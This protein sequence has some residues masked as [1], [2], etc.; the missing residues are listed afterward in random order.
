[1][2]RA[3][4]A[5][6]T[7]KKGCVVCRIVD[8]T[9]SQS[10]VFNNCKILMTTSNSGFNFWG[11]NQEISFE[12]SE[13]EGCDSMW[14]TISVTGQRSSLSIMKT[15]IRDG[16]VSVSVPTSGVRLNITDSEQIMSV[17]IS[18]K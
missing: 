18:I 10:Y 5:N 15:K 14:S 3:T 12:N 13:I 17:Y 8:G 9:S 4:L 11:A 16:Y 2:Y 1:M 6:T 7:I